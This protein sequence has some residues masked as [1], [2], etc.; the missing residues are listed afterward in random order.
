[1]GSVEDGGGGVVEGGGEERTGVEGIIFSWVLFFF[2]C[3]SRGQISRH[4]G[5]REAGREV[6][7]R[8]AKE[9]EGSVQMDCLPRAAAPPACFTS[10]PS[11]ALVSPA[12]R[13]EQS[14]EQQQQQQKTSVVHTDTPSRAACAIRE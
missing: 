10:P 9:R 3:Y 11:A 2:F 5:G 1:M 8:L 4:S 13:G 14:G 7:G 6:G 12:Y